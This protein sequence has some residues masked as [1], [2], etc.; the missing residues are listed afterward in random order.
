M[1]GKFLNPPP[2]GG[3]ACQN[4]AI[5]RNKDFFLPPPPARTLGIS[6]CCN[7]FLR[8]S[9]SSH[10]HVHAQVQTKLDKIHK[11]KQAEYDELMKKYKKEEKVTS[12]RISVLRGCGILRPC[13]FHN[14]HCQFTAE[15]WSCLVHVRRM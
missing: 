12:V 9:H 8:P 3:V 2:L 6:W 1:Y 14:P 13:P 5:C 4:N 11:E 7:S 10:G 15:S